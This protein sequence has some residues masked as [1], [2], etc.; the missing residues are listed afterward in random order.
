MKVIKTEIDGKLVIGIVFENQDDIE[1]LRA[2]CG[3]S[4]WSKQIENSSTPTAPTEAAAEFV[5]AITGI[6]N[7][8]SKLKKL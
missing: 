3:G 1:S 6:L 8:L 2:F 4:I 7:P 5:P